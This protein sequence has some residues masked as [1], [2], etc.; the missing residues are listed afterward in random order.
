MSSLAG[1]GAN[2]IELGSS[3]TLGYSPGQTHMIPKGISADPVMTADMISLI[4]SNCEYVLLI[5]LFAV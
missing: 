3:V 1:V 2:R 5:S 4:R